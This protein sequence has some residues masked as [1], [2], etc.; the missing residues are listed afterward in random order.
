MRIPVTQADWPLAINTI[1]KEIRKR[2]PAGKI[3]FEKSREITAKL[4]GYQSVHDVQKDLGTTTTP[5]HLSVAGMVKS[6]TVRALI[7]Y[8]CHPADVEPIFLKL[9]W[10]RLS[11]WKLTSDYDQTMRKPKELGPTLPFFLDEM[12][13]YHEYKSPQSLIDLYD[14]GQIPGESYAVKGNGLMYSRCDL[15]SMI[16]KLAITSDELTEIGFI[17]TL[18]DFYREHLFSKMWT[19]IDKTITQDNWRRYLPY[20]VI[21]EETVDGQYSLFHQGFNGYFP[22][23]YDSAS[24]VSTITRILLGKVVEPQSLNGIE[25]DCSRNYKRTNASPGVPLVPGTGMQLSRGT[26]IDAQG[27][28]LIRTVPL[29]TYQDLLQ[30]KWIATWLRP[31]MDGYKSVIANGVIESGIEYDHLLLSKLLKRAEGLSHIS[32]K[33]ASRTDLDNALLAVFTTGKITFESLQASGHFLLAG[34]GQDGWCEEDEFEAMNDR[35]LSIADLKA[36]GVSVLQYHPELTPY[37]DE[38]AIGDLYQNFVGSHRMILA[39]I[40]RSPSFL[41]YVVSQTLNEILSVSVNR[42]MILAS[43][44]LVDLIKG[45]ISKND[46]KD[47][48]THGAHLINQYTGQNRAISNMIEFGRHLGVHNPLYISHGPRTPVNRKSPSDLFSELSI[49]GRKFKS[50]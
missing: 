25:V 19:P 42:D 17:G 44:V 2:W 32:I 20:Q 22:G 18:N 46:I 48:W 49:Q 33:A 3:K 30:H 12:G 24:A 38:V 11:V 21:A 41:I 47:C 1:S 50:S 10:H 6:M 13:M 34:E 27:Q 39:C 23:T 29:T 43:M 35:D 16:N 45:A 5:K 9:P 36:C 14:E 8:D 28:T 40:E 7:H 15:E 31:S 4:F 37:F 26:R